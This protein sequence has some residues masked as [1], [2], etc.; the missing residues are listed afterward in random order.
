MKQ[1]TVSELEQSSRFVKVIELDH[2]ELVP[3]VQ[4]NL[5]HRTA[6]VWAYYTAN[7]LL[8]LAV[9]MMGAYDYT[10]HYLSLVDILVH[11]SYG[12]LLFFPFLL[13][14]HEWIHG[15]SYRWLG[16]A[17]VSYVA[18]WRKLV[19]FA[20]ADRFV[21]GRKGFA[22]LAFSPFVIINTLLIIACLLTGGLWKWTF[23]AAMVIHTGGCAGDFALFNYFYRHRKQEV[24]T[25]DD[26]A[27]GKSYFYHAP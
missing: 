13:I 2:R 9:A 6:V 1:L 15:L 17:K 21:V 24:Y 25:Y 5:R 14:L 16:A 20:L 22:L 4:Y 8:L 23:L 3:F 27:E 7:M 26:A 10:R 12:F 19:F 11:C 18:Q